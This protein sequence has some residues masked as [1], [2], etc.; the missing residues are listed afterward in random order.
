MQRANRP[1]E[2]LEKINENAY[3]VD[4][5]REYGVSWTLNVVDHNPYFSDENIKTLKGTSLQQGNDDVPKEEK[6]EEFE[7]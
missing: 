5:M 2:I 1:L 6:Q 3:K 7:S 4:F